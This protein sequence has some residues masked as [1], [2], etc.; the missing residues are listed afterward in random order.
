MGREDHDRLQR[1]LELL[2]EAYADSSDPDER[3]QL[4]N[5]L[6]D[7]HRQIDQPTTPGPDSPD[8]SDADVLVP[9]PVTA[10]AIPPAVPPPVGAYPDPWSANDQLRWWDGTR[11][12]R[13]AK[14]MRGPV[15]TDQQRTLRLPEGRALTQGELAILGSPHERHSNGERQTDATHPAGGPTLNDLQVGSR[16]Q[17]PATS[18]DPPATRPR[19]NR[20]AVTGFVLSLVS[21]VLYEI[22]IVPILAVIFSAVGLGTYRPGEQSGRW[23]AGVGLVVGVVYTFMYLAS[24]GYLG[25]EI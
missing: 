17:V 10:A 21:I 24:Y 25:L 15:L 9:D 13:R 22:W 2:E 5:E 14:G 23:M 3:R 18:Q 6:L 19:A 1:R 20:A 8:V 11:W 4:R 16:E 12:A 7:V